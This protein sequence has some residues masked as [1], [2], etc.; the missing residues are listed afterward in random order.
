MNIL[1]IALATLLCGPA[2][3]DTY[4]NPI[5]YSDYSD[6]DI[7]AVDGEYWMT[8]SSF[9]CVPGLQILHS[10]NL[11]DWELVGAAVRADNPYWKGALNHPD[12]GGGIWAPSIRFRKSNGRY[13]IFWGDP[14]RGVFQINTDDPRG[15]WTDPIMVM[16]CKGVIDPC[17]LFDDD[18]KVY[19]VHAWAGSRAGFKSTLIVST[20]D[21]EC[22]RVTGEQV[23]VFDGNKTGNL[24]V[25]G[26]KFYKKDGRYWIFAPAGGVKTGWQ[27]ALRSDSPFGPYEWRR[28]CEAAD[29]RDV[30]AGRAAPTKAPH[31]GGWV[32]D[33]DGL[34]WFI[35]F[36]D[37]G[38]VGRVIHLQP[39]SW[40]EDGWCI[41]GRDI[42][43]DGV[44]EPVKTWRKPRGEGLDGACTSAV[45]TGTGFT[46]TG[47]PLNWQWHGQ[48]D[49]HWGY[50]NPSEGCIRLNCISHEP[51]WKN[52]WD[53][54]NL[55]LEKVVGPEMTLCSKLVFNPSYGGDRVG[56]TVFGLDYATIEMVYDGS[57]VSIQT[58]QC[59][60]ADKGTPERIG[61][62]R[63]T[64]K[65][66]STIGQKA[67]YTTY[68]RVDI[69]EAVGDI[70][71]P[72]VKCQFSYS[73]DGQ[74][75]KPLGD[76]F[77]ARE[78]VWIG[79]KV[80]FFATADI[81]RNDGGSVEVY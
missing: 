47:I 73:L 2:H 65:C 77:I 19:L 21:S 66:S 80:G 22:T 20:L 15:E 56:L 55:L 52:L 60:D 3:S 14:D 67:W 10:R 72:V 41:I 7:E 54:P 24:T 45:E 30:R 43:G 48:P 49:I 9:N 69:K 51:G 27:L 50:T 1:L 81:K 44:G 32:T 38:P 79:A 23:I 61:E 57:E 63:T 25:E 28:V 11:V 16:K 42:D 75:Y 39:M 17:P 53:S 76:T 33:G 78:G 12:H 6:P 37:R 64:L 29:T 74:T 8:S 13:Y 59:H 58:R 68:L 62:Q 4:S 46:G 40:T 35:H 36:E 71:P 34:S 18:G 26:P 5:L 31:Q 70:W